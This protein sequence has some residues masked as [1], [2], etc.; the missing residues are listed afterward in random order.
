MCTHVTHRLL[1]A[2]GTS[3]SYATQDATACSIYSTLT[4]LPFYIVP[5]VLPVVRTRSFLP[6]PSPS[7]STVT[8][9]EPPAIGFCPGE[10]QATV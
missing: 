3:V 8:S 6:G 7:Y 1:A 9:T 5:L 10:S 2:T 4:F